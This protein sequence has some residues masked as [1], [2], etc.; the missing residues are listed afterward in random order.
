MTKGKP[1]T[2]AE[3]VEAKKASLPPEVFDVFNEQIA[4]N[5]DGHSATLFQTAVVDAIVAKLGITR[6][7][8]FARRYLDIE[9]IYKKAG[10]SVVYDKP[11]YCEDY[12]A[13]F[14]FKKKKST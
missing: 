11:G 5:W 9:P 13:S 8:V 4:Q 6:A 1:I 3:V 2:P 7:E 14:T 10:W 12:E